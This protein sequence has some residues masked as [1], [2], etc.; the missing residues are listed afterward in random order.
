M[1]IW[2]FEDSPILWPIILTLRSMMTGDPLLTVGT[3]RRVPHVN[4]MDEGQTAAAGQHWTG[5]LKNRLSA[6]Y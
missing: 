1:G 4:N 5:T 3:A 2:E 6:H